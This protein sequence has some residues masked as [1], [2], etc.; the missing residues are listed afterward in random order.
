MIRRRLSDNR[1]RVRPPFCRTRP[2]LASSNSH[3]YSNRYTSASPRRIARGEGATCAQQQPMAKKQQLH[4]LIDIEAL[5][6]EMAGRFENAYLIYCRKSTDDPNNQQNSIKYQDTENIKCAR[7]RGLP[8]AEL[9]FPGFCTTGIIHERHSGHKEDAYLKIT[10]DGKVTYQIV[11]PK[12]AI[13]MQLL[14][15]GL[16]KGIVVLSW[17]RLSR[18]DADSALIKKLKRRGATFHF[19]NTTYSEGSAGG[20]H[21]DIDSMFAGYYSAVISDKVR[22]SL[23]EMRSEG[24]C[25]YRSPLGYLDQ[26]ADNK[27]I[28]PERGPIVRE[29][30]AKY[31]T[32]EWS[33][34]ALAEWAKTQGLTTKP[35][36]RPRTQEEILDELEPSTIPALS[37]AVTHKTIENI[38]TNPF[39]IG[40][41]KVPGSRNSSE[42]W[43]DGIHPPL[44]SATTFQN[45]QA[46]L[47]RRNVSVHYPQ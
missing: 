10:S 29:I 12:F 25:T 34:T 20:L 17:D 37:K 11:R 31:E 6:A 5:A 47:R 1:Q 2:R 16:L 8:I 24:K 15:R 30:F 32:G 7:T 3:A 39:Y 36:R 46:V 42:E 13:L 19:Q 9:T 22:H 18:N 43:I 27:V 33:Q 41:L 44:I 28:D 4:D 14:A 38:L 45:V 23:K 40:K 35:I 21:M 26:G